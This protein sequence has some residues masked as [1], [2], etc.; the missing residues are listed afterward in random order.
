M[1]EVSIIL[2]NSYNLIFVQA[3]VRTTAR[4]RPLDLQLGKYLAVPANI[5]SR[6]DRAEYFLPPRAA[7]PSQPSGRIGGQ[8]GRSIV[9]S[10]RFDAA[11]R[12]QR[13]CIQ[14]RHA[15]ARRLGDEAGAQAVGADPDDIDADELGQRANDPVNFL[16]AKQCP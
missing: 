5:S 14:H 9:A 4:L 7:R 8:L 6:G 10:Q 11:M 1:A 12:R 15:L 13:H 16:A 2:E 3:V